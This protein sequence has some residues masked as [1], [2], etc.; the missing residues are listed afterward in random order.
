MYGTDVH[1]WLDGEV[2]NMNVLTFGASEPDFDGT[3]AKM[4]LR[5][6]NEWALVD[7]DT[8]AYN[9]RALCEI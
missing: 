5:Y 2:V 7:W 8:N 6:C 4:M 3:D 9:E 1:Y